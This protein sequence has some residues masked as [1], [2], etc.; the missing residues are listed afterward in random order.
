MVATSLRFNILRV[1]LVTKCSRVSRL[2]NEVSHGGR[3][4]AQIDIKE[5]GG[6]SLSFELY[7]I[8]FYL[9]DINSPCV[10]L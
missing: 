3:K 6:L 7:N 9:I 2:S 1:S 4:L 10:V 5:V 8:S